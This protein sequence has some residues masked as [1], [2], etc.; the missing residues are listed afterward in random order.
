MEWSMFGI[1]Y[2][3]AYLANKVCYMTDEN[4]SF[5]DNICHISLP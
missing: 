1:S 5:Y 3:L 2:T 4:R